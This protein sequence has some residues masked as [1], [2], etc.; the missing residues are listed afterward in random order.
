[1]TVT[2][3]QLNRATLERQLLLRREPISVIDAVRRIVAL[4]AQEAPSPYV[5]LWSR[6]EG[7]DAA[8]L[9]AAFAA[10]SIVKA[11]LMRLTLHAVH[12]DD[13]VCFHQAMQP[14]LRA[15]RLG[16]PRFDI[17]GLTKEEA[18]ALVPELLAFA[19]QP[20]SNAD[21]E[22]WLER[23]LGRPL[24]K[25]GVW[26]AMRSYA[27][28]WHAVAG[29]PWS[30]GRRP[31]Y[32]AA[33]R[34]AEVRPAPDVALEWLVRRYL[35]GFGPASVQ[36]IA[37]FAMI[38]RARARAAI[39]ALGEE[40]VRV[41]GPDGRDLFD[42]PGGVVPPE[43]VPAPPRLLPMWDSVLLA[44]FDRSR[45]VPAP[46]RKLVTRS[47]GDVLP[48]ILVN[49]YVA[50]AWR[51]VDSVIEVTSFH[52]LSADEWSGLAAEAV[53]LL[54]LLAERDPSIYGRYS[55]WWAALPAAQ[56]RRLG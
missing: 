20:R 34:R 22:A 6:V 52:R 14:S 18:D 12:V 26:W 23:R 15:A 37:Q 7:F 1:M 19:A 41:Q 48:T 43:D 47:N 27:P 44:Y 9:D 55:R 50:G 13:Y 33:G 10:G 21:I 17:A 42:V 38:Q 51:P 16:D 32:V 35:E 31:A 54:P 4:Q 28:L 45:I 40:L 53:A 46:Y 2:A 39:D 8:Q 56:I 29:G 11:T 3:G 30:F 5:A 25:P 24:A 49:G 36:D